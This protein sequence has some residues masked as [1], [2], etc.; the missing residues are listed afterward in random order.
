MGE[1]FDV[2]D[3]VEVSRAALA[4]TGLDVPA[5][6]AA[7]SA[8]LAAGPRGLFA[9]WDE[10]DE[11]IGK[12]N[13]P[14]LRERLIELRARFAEQAGAT[15]FGR[16]EKVLAQSPDDAW[17]AWQTALADSIAHFRDAMSARLALFGVALPGRADEASEVVRAVQCIRQQRWPEAY[18][19]IEKLS[20]RAF[21]PTELRAKLLCM[22]GQIQFIHF[23]KLGSAR[24]LLEA[25]EALAPADTSVLGAMGDYWMDERAL[26]GEPDGGLQKATSYYL[27]A[28]KIGPHACEGYQGMGRI[29]ERRK[30]LEAAEVWYQRAVA[31][32][33]GVTGGYD[34]LIQLY[35][36]PELF[37]KHEADLVPL[38]ELAV[39][40]GGDDG[41]EKYVALGREYLRNKHFD[42]ARH[43]FDKAIALD[44]SNPSGY[45]ALAEYHEKSGNP[46]EAE[47]LYKRAIEVAPECCDGYWGLTWF[48][49][50]RGKWREAL[51]WYEK[52]PKKIAGWTGVLRAK[53]GEMYAKLERRPEAEA[54][55]MRALQADNENYMAKDILHTIAQDCYSKLD[56]RAGAERIYAAIMNILGRPYAA[57]Y[58]NQLGN[59][60]YHFDEYD[61]AAA[62]YRLAIEA[63][64]NALYHRNLATTYRIVQRYDEAV[65][66]LERAREID[67]NSERL[68]KEMALIANAKANDCYARGEYMRAIELYGKAIEG[69]PADHVVHVNLARA[70][71]QIKELDQR[72]HALD[73]ALRAYRRADSISPGGAHASDIERLSRKKDFAL[74]YGEK[75]LDW[76]N[77]VTPIAAEVA[78]DLIAAVAGGQ[79]GGLSRKT[80]PRVSPT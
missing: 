2:R 79:P 6:S 34:R 74:S 5:A 50:Q 47:S 28:M 9:V 10:L 44:G 21:M 14:G 55:L 11:Q 12:A 49:E 77:I 32:A 56:D 51:E 78:S 46:D 23:Q 57:E 7:L 73:Q 16:L 4:S 60:S 15:E 70:W 45:V 3:L 67:G 8:I 66:E 54:I 72:M 18:D 64:P 58:H 30:D 41:Y 36:S 69:N 62:E 38:T 65:Q 24:S 31:E 19:Q 63:K 17:T 1:P 75:V 61:K 22:L 76:P 26:E 68:A 13:A 40:L 27:E 33:S 43:W 80:P 35:G 48:Y 25:A 39:A 71:E 29:C 52:A 59:L 53:I 20:A 42:E 37:E